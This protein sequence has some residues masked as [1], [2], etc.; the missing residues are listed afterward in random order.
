LAALS[1]LT[2]TYC[3]VATAAAGEKTGSDYSGKL[4]RM[5]IE[6]MGIH[7]Q[8]R[9]YGRKRGSIFLDLVFDKLFKT[10]RDVIYSVL[11]K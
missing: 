5:L 10:F 6:G 9:F 3:P 2:Y 8:S 11:N 4:K 1:H 7:F